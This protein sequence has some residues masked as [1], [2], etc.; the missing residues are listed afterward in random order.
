[1]LSILD[2]D[3]NNPRF[4]KTIS[5]IKPK[6]FEFITTLEIEKLDLKNARIE[7]FM[8]RSLDESLWVQLILCFKFWMDDN[9]PG[10]EKTDIFIE[11]SINTGFDLLNVQPLK[12]VIDL[13]KFLYHEKSQMN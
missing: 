4:L 2:R 1:V 3:K 12:S 7:K 8:G 5:A 10:L 6:Y 13:G 11:K 9:S